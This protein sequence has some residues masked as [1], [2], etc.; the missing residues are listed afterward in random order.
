MY[1]LKIYIEGEELELFNDEDVSLNSSVQNIKDITKVFTDFTQSFTIPASSGNNKI[2]KHWYNS[3]ITGGFNARTRIDAIIELDF[4]PF[5]KGKI[6]LESIQMKDSKPYAYKITFYGN[7]INLKDLFGDDKLNDLDLS[8]FNHT[9]NSANVKTGITSS[10]SGGDVIYPLISSLRNWT[11]DDATA[12]DIFY[13]AAYAATF[14]IVWNELKPAISLHRIIEAIETKY[15]ITFTADFFGT[16]DFAKLYMWCSREEGQIKTPGIPT[17]I[18]IGGSTAFPVLVNIG[19]PSDSLTCTVTPLAGFEDV[20]YTIIMEWSLTTGTSQ[21]SYQKKGVGSA[22]FTLQYPPDDSGTVTFYIQSD[23][24]FSFTAAIPGIGTSATIVAQGKMYFTDKV[25]VGKLNKGQM[26][27]MRIEDFTKSLFSMFNLT[28]FPLTSLDFQ[29]QT[30]DDW[31]STGVYYDITK[32]IDQ[33][34]GTIERPNLN[35]RISFEYMK[36]G[37]I[38]AKK[39][40]DTNSVGYG[41]L[42]ADF[43]YDGDI[44]NVNPLFENMIGER[45][46]SSTT[47]VVS[48]THVYKALDNKLEA[49]EMNPFIFYNK[50]ITTLTTGV[51]GIAFINDTPTREEL[52]T[53]NNI[54]QENA[55]TDIAVTNSLNYGSELSTWTLMEQTQSLYLNYWSSYITD[56][57]DDKRRVYNFDAVMPLEILTTIQLQDILIISE[58]PFIINNMKIGLTTGKVSFE[59][60]DYLGELTGLPIDY[61]VFNYNI[62]QNL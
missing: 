57:Y 32:Y 10:L 40:K 39:Y 5:K 41:D 14:G 7:L 36:S 48:N 37:T 4:L 56:L 38:L 26:P 2:F 19:S 8:S 15:G 31:Y 52:L 9:F 11:W 33:E 46:S 53:Y 30:L 16:A 25:E 35:R 22:T 34:E 50:G 3:D 18:T 47:G 28:I 62:T 51:D 24:N 13:D 60:L 12:D 17:I 61:N 23:T 1:K 42:Q 6:Q 49:V 45:L 58:K 27:D 59:L 54:G 21:V 29:V 55:L 43:D 44:L 20:D